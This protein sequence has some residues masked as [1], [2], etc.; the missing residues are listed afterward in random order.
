M[1][2]QADLL[3]VQV[4]QDRGA[5]D[6]ARSSLTSALRFAKIALA[7][8]EH[9]RSKLKASWLVS[10]VA[11]LYGDRNAVWRAMSVASDAA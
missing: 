7:K 10:Q 6:Q 4:Y 2:A 8:A 9:P 3:A 11:Y 1:M 5:I